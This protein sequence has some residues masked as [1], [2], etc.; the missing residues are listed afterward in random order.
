MRRLREGGAKYVISFPVRDSRNAAVYQL[1]HASK[2]KQGLRTMKESMHAALNGSGLPE[3]VRAAIHYEL[4][5]NELEIVRELAHRFA[6]REVRWTEGNDRGK[7]ET[8]KKYLLEETPIFPAQFARIKEEL[9][10]AGCQTSTKPLIFTF[11]G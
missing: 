9:A 11:S 10:R 8:V 1:V 5:G 3:A 2:S 6:G 4:E 7:V